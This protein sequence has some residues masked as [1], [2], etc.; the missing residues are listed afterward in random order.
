MA[1]LHFILFKV[2]IQLNNKFTPGIV[3]SYFGIRYKGMQFR[4]IYVDVFV[5]V[6]TR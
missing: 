2:Y 4:Y 6:I 1:C 3:Y 5:W